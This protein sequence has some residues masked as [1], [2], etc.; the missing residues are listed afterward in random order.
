MT[1]ER[2]GP[3]AE[4]K[5]RVDTASSVLDDVLHR[6]DAMVVARAAER[7]LSPMQKLP[8]AMHTDILSMLTLSERVD[9]YLPKGM[10]LIKGIKTLATKSMVLDAAFFERFMSS[11]EDREAVLGFWRRSGFFNT[12]RAISIGTRTRRAFVPP[13]FLGELD[14]MTK[15]MENI[16]IFAGIPEADVLSYVSAELPTLRVL[17]LD[18][19]SEARSPGSHY[20]DSSA[21]ITK[22]LAK[23][24][25]THLLLS[26]TL[27]E[28][29]AEEQMLALA[30]ALPPMLVSLEIQPAM[31]LSENALR[32]MMDRCPKLVRLALTGPFSTGLTPESNWH[33]LPPR[34]WETIKVNRGP[35]VS[36][37]PG[38]EKRSP[39]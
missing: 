30:R 36:W 21:R 13:G 3:P 4:K 10:L 26:N 12:V 35:L 25:L 34:D 17:N 18:I 14:S 28:G 38:F 5:R 32:A 22:M 2:K 27:W 33:R 9:S 20:D 6:V 1:E 19:D 31:T 7:K 8:S 37:L 15:E 11:T 39:L 16:E 29:R 23:S 24:K